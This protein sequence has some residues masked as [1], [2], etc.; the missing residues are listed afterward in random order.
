LEC[1]RDWSWERRDELQR[2]YQQ[3]LRL[4]GQLYSARKQYVQ[5][6]ET[7]RR[8]IV[9]DHYQED[10]HRELM[11]CYMHL[12]ERGQALRHYRYLASWMREELGIRPSAE[13]RALLKYLRNDEDG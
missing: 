11:C 6:A 3:A 2:S 8:L 5:A 13:T 4:L 1:S 7:Y 12:G 9:H 10:A